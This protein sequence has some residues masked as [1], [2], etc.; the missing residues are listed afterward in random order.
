[1]KD[2]SSSL[3]LEWVKVNDWLMETTDHRFRCRKFYSGNVL[4]EP[5]EVRYQLYGPDGIT[6]GPAEPSFDMARRHT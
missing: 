4:N 3:T 5:G 1:M 2:S 6:R